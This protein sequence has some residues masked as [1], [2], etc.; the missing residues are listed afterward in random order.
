VA[1]GVP[2]QAREPDGPSVGAAGIGDTYFPLDGN[3]GIDVLH[4]DVRDTYEF[5]SGLLSGRTTLTL[6]ATQDLSRFNLDFLLKVSQVEVDGIPASF[7]RGNRHELR[8]TPAAAIAAGQVLT[9]EVRYA[10]KPRDATYLGERNWLADAR[11][12]V[13]MNEPHMA[14]WWF[15]ANDHPRDKATMD[16]RIT[17]PKQRKV[18]SNGALLDRVVKGELATTHWR[19]DEPMAPYLAFFAAGDFQVR[20]G[21]LD[22]R[23]FVAAV[24]KQL[25]PR[26]RRAS[27]RMML[28]SAPLT[29][30]LETQLGPY[31]FA[32]TGGVVTSL[33]PGFA[34][35]TQ[36]RPVYPAVGPDSTSLVVHE[37]AHQWFGN[38][39]AVERW[40]DIWLNE[41]FAT[42]MEARWGELSGRGTADQWLANSYGALKDNPA[43]WQLRISDPGADRVFD[44][45]VY[46][47]GAMTLQALR[48]RIGEDA[49]WTTLRTWASSRAGGQG[50]V[51][52]FRALAATVSGQ[53]L[54]AFF[55]AWLVA[56][57]RPARTA[58]NGF[59]S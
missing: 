3:G 7:D 20:K 57:V 42:F 24:S 2:A 10:G 49:F 9:V 17:V 55:D 59:T 18:I 26:L 13:T 31:P 32:S 1:T 40:R 15:P 30:W 6:R 39:V 34:L 12:V 58:A 35:E 50:R 4:Y 41:G 56:T 5:G 37:L 44:H 43:F 14:P 33:S 19:A 28:Q 52:D 11:E 29:A 47:R 8:I 51:E 25:P 27:M 22:G 48:N 38:S 53:D 16:V 21:S 23:P 54:G 45:A 36:T 46:V